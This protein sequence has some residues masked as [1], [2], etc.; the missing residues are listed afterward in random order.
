MRYSTLTSRV[1]MGGDISSR[2]LRGL[3]GVCKPI[4]KRR[5]GNPYLLKMRKAVQALKPTDKI[6][7]YWF[8]EPAN[9]KHCYDV[10]D[11]DRIE[12]HPFEMIQ[13]PIPVGYDRVLTASFGDWRTPR[14]EDND[15]GDLIFDCHKPYSPR[16]SGTSGDI[17][18]TAPHNRNPHTI[19]R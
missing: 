12:L 6:G 13:I 1:P 10:K 11:F 3:S 19:I 9:D 14:M 17:R 5:N 15:H 8:Y 7:E 18:K 4:L 2:I 16:G